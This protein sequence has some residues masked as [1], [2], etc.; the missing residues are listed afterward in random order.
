[1]STNL[2]ATVSKSA[3]QSLAHQGILVHESFHQIRELVR[4]RLGDAYA[5][6]FAEPSIR[7]DGSA[8]DWYTPVQGTARRLVDLPGEEQRA[9]RAATVRMAQ[10]LA[11][12]ASELRQSGIA[13]QVTRGS[14]LELALRYPD[15]SYI[16]LVG[17]QPLFVCWG[18]GPGTPG[19][20]PQ[21][22]TR[23][24]QTVTPP[25]PSAPPPDPAAPADETAPRRAA[26]SLLWLLPPLLLVLLFFL[27][28][29]SFGGNAPLIPG[30]NFQGPELPFLPKTPAAP[31]SVPAEESAAAAETLRGEIDALRKK[32]HELAAACPAADPPPVTASTPGPKESELIIPSDA[33]ATM[34]FLRG[35]WLCER[36][37]VNKADGQILTV[38]YDFDAD[39]AGTLTV[40]QQGRADCVGSAAASMREGRLVIE[41]ERQI[42]PNGNNYAAET[43]ECARGEENRA[44][45]RGKSGSGA[46]WGGHVPFRKIR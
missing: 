12:V 29:T 41:A 22:L 7:R 35:R 5:L 24:G 14:V 8:I 20:Q 44:M 28:T 26:F 33:P 1:M 27:L 34:E 10:D 45:C 31:K 3:V 19:M 9:A 36:G 42:C 4:S 17:E 16:Y 15:E 23:L 30:F 43:I 18:F 38:I 11:G 37:L 39:G 13:P 2:V 40:R 32:L 25:G 6:L 21:D 46:D